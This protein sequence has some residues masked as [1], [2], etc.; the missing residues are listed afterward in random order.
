[1]SIPPRAPHLNILGA[2]FKRRALPKIIEGGQLG[3]LW[4]ISRINPETSYQ[5][6][7][8][9]KSMRALSSSLRKRKKKTRVDHLSPD[10]TIAFLTSPMP[11]QLHQTKHFRLNFDHFFP[12]PKCLHK[13]IYVTPYA[14]RSCRAS[15]FTCSRLRRSVFKTFEKRCSKVFVS[16]SFLCA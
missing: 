3:L 5:L 11:S 1:M 12:C 13:Q 6:T 4:Q 10:Y 14:S 8:P 16:I 15:V 9:P 7:K 2:L